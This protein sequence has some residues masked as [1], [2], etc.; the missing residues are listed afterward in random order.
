MLDPV[1]EKLIDSFK[2]ELKDGLSTLD[3][4]TADRFTKLEHQLDKMVSRE[5]H[6][7]EVKR[8]DSEIKRIDGNVHANLTNLDKLAATLKWAVGAL[9]SF[10]ALIV[11]SFGF[12][13]NNL[14]N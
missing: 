14:V 10:G 5:V 7:A 12:V 4:N 8:I 11:A 2:A 9:V 6:E 13:I 3:K 1:A